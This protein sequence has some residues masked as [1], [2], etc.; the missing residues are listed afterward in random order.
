MQG[1]DADSDLLTDRGIWQCVGRQR[2]AE[3]VPA[4]L[5]PW[6]VNHKACVGWYGLV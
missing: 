4:L 5:G 6:A 1:A 3:R 2:K